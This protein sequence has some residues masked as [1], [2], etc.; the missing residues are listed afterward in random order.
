VVNVV[1]N[2]SAPTR[3]L[4]HGRVGEPGRFDQSLGRSRR[5]VEIAGSG[6]QLAKA[7]VNEYFHSRVPV[8]VET[9]VVIRSNVDLIYSFAVVDVTEEAT[10]SLAPSSE[11]QVAEII[12]ENHYGV[13][14]IYPGETLTVR[15]IDLSAGTHVYIDEDTRKSVGVELESH[16]AEADFSKAFGTP[17]GTDSY[18]HLLGARLAGA[19]C[20]PR[21]PSTSRLWPH[22]PELMCGPSMF[23]RW[24]TSATDT[25]R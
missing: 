23:R 24:T 2:C 15:N 4:I 8:N 6:E 18:Q 1:G 3:R 11:Y 5:S 17:A 14:V 13:G 21:M 20:R 9:Q 19:D 25:F 12:D 7:P 16:A 22:P 10:F